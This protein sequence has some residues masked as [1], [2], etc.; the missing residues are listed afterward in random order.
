MDDQQKQC[1][2]FSAYNN[3]SRAGKGDHNNI[4]KDEAGD[5]ATNY[6]DCQRLIEYE[7]EFTSSKIG[8]RFRNLKGSMIVATYEGPELEM[9]NDE[10]GLTSIL[11]N[12]T[13]ATLIAVNG[14]TIEHLSFQQAT[15]VLANAGRP[16]HL[17]FRER[18]PIDD[19][20]LCPPYDEM[21]SAEGLKSTNKG[22]SD[23]MTED[24]D[25]IPDSSGVALSQSPTCN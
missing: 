2:S 11:P 22:W 12:V 1:P 16:I 13:G 7:V 8:L 17:R 9:L 15:R 3:L 25:E 21:S 6:D 18:V 24:D 5:G 19:D 4:W 23:L 14:Q 20:L 10:D